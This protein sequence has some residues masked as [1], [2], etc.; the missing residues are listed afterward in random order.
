MMAARMR[1]S[2]VVGVVALFVMSSDSLSQCGLV[3]LSNPFSDLIVVQPGDEFFVTVTSSY[4]GGKK[5][6]LIDLGNGE[7]AVKA[8]VDEVIPVEYDHAGEYVI[9]AKLDGNYLSAITVRVVGVPPLEPSAMEVM[10]LSSSTNVSVGSVYAEEGNYPMRMVASAAC[11]FELRI[12]GGGT[13]WSGSLDAGDNITVITN[14]PTTNTWTLI[15]FVN[16]QQKGGTHVLS[17]WTPYRLQI[18][19][20]ELVDGPDCAPVGSMVGNSNFYMGTCHEAELKVVPDPWWASNNVCAFLYDWTGTDLTNSTGL[21]K[22][23]DYDDG[24]MK[25]VTVSCASHTTGVSTVVKVVDVDLTGWEPDPP[26]A[27][28]L[29]EIDDAMEVNPGV[30]LVHQKTQ[31]HVEDPKVYIGSYVISWVDLATNKLI[32]LKEVGGTGAWLGSGI[33]QSCTSASW[34]VKYKVK[35]EGDGVWSGTDSVLVKLTQTDITCTDEVNLVYMKVDLDVDADYDGNVSVDAPDDP[36]EVSQGGLVCVTNATCTNRAELVLREVEPSSWTGTVTLTYTTDKIKIFD[37]QT[38]GNEVPNPTNFSASLLPKT[39]WVQGEKVSDNAQDI[40]ITL[41]ATPGG[42]ADTNTFTVI[43]VDI[44]ETHVFGL[45]GTSNNVAYSLTSDSTTNVTWTID[46]DLGTNGAQFASGPFAPG[47]TNSVSGTMNVWVSPGPVTNVYTIKAYANDLTNCYDTALLEVAQVVLHP[48][49]GDFVPGKAGRTMISTLQDGLYYTSVP[50]TKADSGAQTNDRVVVVTAHLPPG[51]AGTSVYFRVVDPDP[52]DLSSYETD[53][54]TGDN[55]DPGAPAGT[56][57]AANAVAELKTINGWQVA[58]AEVTLTVTARY[59]GDNYQVH[60][61]LDP[62]WA[63]TNDSTCV[64]VAWKRIYVEEDQMYK[65]GSDLNADFAPDANTAPDNVTVVDASVF[66]VTDNVRIFDADN[67]AGETAQITNIVGNTLHLDVDLTNS[68]NAGY[69]AADKGAAVAKPGD[70]ILDANVTGQVGDAYGDGTDGT[71]GGCFVEVMIL[72][73]GGNR[74]PYRETFGSAA[75]RVS[76]RNVWFDNKG[77]LNYI[78]VCG[79]D[80]HNVVGDNTYGVASSGNNYIYVY[81][82]EIGD[83]YGANAGKANPDT[84]A[85]EIGHQFGLGQVDNNHPAN[86][87]CHEGNGTDYC[88]MSYQRD[89]TDENSEFCHD[90]PNHVDGVRDTADGL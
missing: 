28:N 9:I 4:K 74:V 10:T 34:P 5:R 89:R 45:V 20:I 51:M 77:S 7:P 1:W 69:G 55:H 49:T 90:N 41:E 8:K 76:F 60:C 24:G 81:L 23:L 32:K 63:T 19:D 21:Y 78:Y 6:V 17:P 67:P 70:G 48:K 43:K 29:K 33:T 86:V 38:D 75:A 11:S 79:A 73:D 88:L 44:V 30:L 62:T 85:H 80:Y 39:Y 36:L 25:T 46:P 12:Y 72:A 71:D 57:S 68:Y 54:V 59:A 83:D 15:K 47:T 82:G 84:T 56:L 16:G 64:L 2:V 31:L 14:G 37:A 87:W 53:T 13:A 26:P 18:D 58:A 35:T 40:T 22:D 65:V 50:T 27:S 3:D 52:D 66:S 42:A 61:S